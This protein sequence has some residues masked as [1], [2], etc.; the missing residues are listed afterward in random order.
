MEALMLDIGELSWKSHCNTTARAAETDL[1]EIIHKIVT[2]AP[3]NLFKFDPNSLRAKT[4]RRRSVNTLARFLIR[5]LTSE[6]VLCD[7][8][9][10]FSEKKTAEIMRI[11][12]ASV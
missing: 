8:S 11:V 3:K 12:L 7:Y 4:E 5:K 6:I 9:A 10:C 2:N 1:K